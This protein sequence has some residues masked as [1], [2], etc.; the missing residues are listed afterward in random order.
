MTLAAV[1][2]N[3]EAA[4]GNLLVNGNFQRRL[5]G[6][7]VDV[8]PWYSREHI[9]PIEPQLDTTVFPG[10]RRAV[11][12]AG[13]HQGQARL[14]QPDDVDPKHKKYRL[15]FRIKT[16]DLTDEVFTGA[17]VN[18]NKPK[19][20]PGFGNEWARVLVE[21]PQWRQ[22]ERIANIESTDGKATVS[23]FVNRRSP[24]TLPEKGTAGS[25]A[26][27]FCR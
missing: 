21:A 20:V 2:R 13:H 27:S 6:W 24:S 23:L 9:Q 17:T 15:R 12:H 22:L 14:S 8:P 5:E 4:E 10:Q 26:W 25:A 11:A 19:N 1:A 16:K 3:T 7:K 18:W